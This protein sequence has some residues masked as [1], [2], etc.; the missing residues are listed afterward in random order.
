MDLLLWEQV[1]EGRIPDSLIADALGSA[2]NADEEKVRKTI[3]PLAMRLLQPL[4]DSTLD[5]RLR[6]LA[7]NQWEARRAATARERKSV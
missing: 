5:Q 2:S 6:A 4:R 3:R 1:D 7:Y